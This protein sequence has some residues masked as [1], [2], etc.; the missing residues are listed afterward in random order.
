MSFGGPGSAFSFAAPTRPARRVG[1]SGSFNQGSSAAT[2]PSNGGPTPVDPPA[3]PTLG[4]W[5]SAAQH[6]RETSA[7]SIGS[8]AVTGH[9]HPG[10]GDASSR[11]FSSILSPSLSATANGGSH[12]DGGEGNG[13]AGKP[14]VYSREF[15]LSLYD[16]DKARKR[17]LE[18]AV[19]EIATRDL[20]GV[21]AA[22]HK[23]WAMQEYREGEKDLFST[24][25]HPANARPSRMNRTE[26]SL[27][28]TSANGTL[29]LSTLGTLPRD[30]D[31][32]LAS[33][34]VRSPGITDK[35]G[36]LGSGTGRERRTRD[37]SA[38]ATMGIMGGV[39]GGIAA[40]GSP[41]ARKKDGE[42]AKDVWQGGRWRRGAAQEADEG[43]KRPSA[44]GSR[45]F[46]LPD[47]SES[48]EASKPNGDD[49]VPDSWEETAKDES[50]PTGSAMLNGSSLSSPNDSLPT[51][52]ELTATV[53]GSLALDSDPLDDAL[54]SH[55][56]SAA[57][58]GAST[59]SRAAP[60]PGL[61]SLP[62]PEVHWQYRDPSG[63]IQGPFSASMMH[64][65]YRQQFFTP[66][67][68]VKRTIDLDF[69]SLENLI[70]RTGDSEKPFLAT[71]PTLA[72]TA[73]GSAFSSAPGTPQIAS[74]W[75]G[76]TG[77][78]QT[79]LDQLAGAL[80]QG[81]FGAAGTGSFYEPFGSNASSPALQ[82]QTLPQ[83]LANRAAVTPGGTALDPWGTPL[84]ATAS[85]AFQQ[86]FPQQQQAQSPLLQQ[87]HHSGL[88]SSI[89]ILR[90][91]QQQQQQHSPSLQSPYIQPGST[92][93][94]G[95]PSPL[96]T[97]SYFD[98]RQLAV[99]SPAQQ[100]ASSAWIGQQVPQQIHQ[101]QQHQQQP[102][103]NLASPAAPVAP[104]AALQALSPTPQP[105]TAA[106]PS[107]IG[108]PAA[109]APESQASVPQQQPAAL[110][111]VH[112]S[113]VSETVVVAG[114]AAEAPAVVAVV[115]E[116]SVQQQAPVVKEEQ[117]K[118]K[119]SP[120]KTKE[121][122][123]APEPTPASV[124]EAEQ[125]AF[126]AVSPSTSAKPAAAAP[127]AKDDT[128]VAAAAPAV[129]P[130]LREIQQAEARE[131]DRRK[132]AARIQAAQANIQAA[133]RA[134]AAEA[135]LA[136]EQLPPSANWAAG[137]AQVPA[138]K[139]PPVAPWTKPAVAAATKP[140]GK[141]LKE[142]QEEE[143]R[144]KKAQVAAQQ[145]AAAGATAGRG[146][147]GS[148]GQGATKVANSAPWT[149]VA[150]KPAVAH[151]TAPAAKPVI[152]GLPSAATSVTVTRTAS[153][154]GLPSKPATPV[155]RPAV[156]VPAQVVPA[157]KP[158]TIIRSVNVNG[159]SSVT[160]VYDAENPPPPSPE[161][162]AWIRQ[163]LK[164]LTVPM[165]EFIQMLLSFPLDASSD[166]LE[167]ISDSVYANSSTL[168]GR[169]FANDYAA[170]RKN[171]VAVRYP[172][173]F[174]KGKVTAKPTSMAQVLASQPAPKQ[175]EWSVKVAGSKKKKGGK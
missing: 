58:S 101:Q 152:P 115:E 105:A 143:E 138:V 171:D 124:A 129:S 162:V 80:G 164:G 60:P 57:P 116:V 24:S 97:P 149:T 25:I 33:P 4:S 91:L 127:W 47:E 134:A 117:P 54:L 17:P 76:S 75:G 32:A 103:S 63:Q 89:D 3:N 108:P 2:S 107:P 156:A 46:P 158:A 96:P 11:S 170:R 68:R 71:K 109:S 151:T 62:Q 56:R 93:V 41:A 160:P 163:A 14:F 150:V 118:K 128:V 66:D 59:P 88:P 126:P 31:R 13:R 27:S 94:F 137:P 30:R 112:Q 26:S 172:Q 36:I 65:W 90:Q 99:G 153:S 48:N 173:I 131:A 1:S 165:D 167:I 106:V 12:A 20:G 37:R 135:A 84:P 51:E 55:K 146:Y 166:V 72:G 70:R 79:P 42:G 22:S 174:A 50:A 44:F 136:A 161:F 157:P 52:P 29:D 21:N 78:A 82:S 102:W 85:P 15:L 6:E 159:A 61:S 73:P 113:Q 130:S 148:I 100:A 120:S 122:K 35:D 9:A 7:G 18:L 133:Q 67:L 19:N 8:G 169:R 86:L 5:S 53:L 34:G 132:A 23:P 64:D 16:E 139:Q 10:A 175:T 92:D 155:A 45:R 95:R 81:R 144:R 114:P 40:A 111:P 140:A 121:A 104:N 39:L 28:T 145:Q 43:E 87:A 125:P 147:A 154:T 74:A 119:A 49:A 141:S 83:L 69:E 168:D 142:I 38:G 77:R 123:A 110:G 98:P